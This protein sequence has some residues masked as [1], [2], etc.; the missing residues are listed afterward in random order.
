MQC[1]QC[2]RGEL[3]MT[4]CPFCHGDGTRQDLGDT[5]CPSC[6]GFGRYLECD[7][8]S[9]EAMVSDLPALERQDNVD[10]AADAVDAAQH[11][12]VH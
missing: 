12:D 6:E 3:D 11:D 4:I 10:R 7:T 9:Y 2:K 5:E 8:C 1:P